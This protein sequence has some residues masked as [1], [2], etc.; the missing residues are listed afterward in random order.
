MKLSTD[1]AWQ[2][3]Q[4]IFSGH[5]CPGEGEHKLVDFIRRRKMQPGYDPNETHCMYGLDADLIMLA[6]ATHEPHFV[7]LRE[8]VTFGA[9]TF[10]ERQR[11]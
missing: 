4:V 8:V 2:N 7:L 11:Q 9:S 10:K 5:D 1:P 3:C 6:L